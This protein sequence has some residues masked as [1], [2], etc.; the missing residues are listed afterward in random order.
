MVWRNNNGVMSLS[1]SKRVA[2]TTTL[3]A[4]LDPGCFKMNPL[5]HLPTPRGRNNQEIATQTIKSSQI[6]SVWSLQGFLWC[7]LGCVF[8]RK[9]RRSCCCHHLPV[10]VSGCCYFFSQLH[11]ILNLDTHLK[12]AGRYQ[13]QQ[14]TNLTL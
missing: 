5:P 9:E 6:D 4:G 13:C 10:T 11:V 14:W 1:W 12:K 2:W 7:L 8:S 3:L